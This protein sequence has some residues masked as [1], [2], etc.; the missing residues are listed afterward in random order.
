MPTT[1][2]APLFHLALLIMVGAYMV[3]VEL[4]QDPAQESP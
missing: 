3:A 4:A 2:L 1:S